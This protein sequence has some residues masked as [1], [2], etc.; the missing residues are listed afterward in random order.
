VEQFLWVSIELKYIRDDVGIPIIVLHH[1]ND[2]GETRWSKDIDADADLSIKLLRDDQE[3]VP[4]TAA[5][6]FQERAIVDL[7]V[8]KNRDGET[9]K[10]QLWFQKTVQR[11][12]DW[13]Q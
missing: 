3:S 4:A 8:A 11:F 12:V 1:S 7:D 6:N 10:V 5:N 13:P 2:D 9:P